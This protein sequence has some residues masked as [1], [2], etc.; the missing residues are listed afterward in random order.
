[1]ITR[2]T[3]LAGIASTAGLWGCALRHEALATRSD[4]EVFDTQAHGLFPQDARLETIATGYV[5]CEGPTWDTDRNALYFT[6]VPGNTAYR[7]RRGQGVDVLLQPSG[8]AVAEGFREPGANGLWHA[9]DGRL[10]V[11]NHG[12]RRVEA[13]DLATTS[14]ASLVDHFEGRRFNS[15][16]DVVEAADGALYFTDPP[17]GLTGLNDS[18]LKEMAVN[19]V[20]RLSPTGDVRRLVSDMTFPNGIALSPDGRRLYVSQSDPAAPEI[21]VFHLDSRGGVLVGSTFFDAAPLMGDDAPGLPDGMAV[22]RSGH[23]FAT[24]PG[25]VLLLSPDGRLLGRIRTGRA[26]AN[27]AF[28]E[29]G[30]TLFITANDRVFRIP[31]LM[32]GVQ[33]S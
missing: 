22:C 18:P 28:G 16:N 1:M 9:R 17:Y 13:I 5:W 26:T 12:L 14:R 3:A 29:D 24:G 7:W 15:P 31:T 6:D 23:V 30:R 2:R 32:T 25:G 20:Y 33:W 10:I 27:C 8:A 19:G 4:I 11:C 21:R